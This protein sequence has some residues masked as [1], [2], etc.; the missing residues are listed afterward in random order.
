MAIEV[1][2]RF[3]Y[4]YRIDE[5]M[6]TRVIDEIEKHMVTDSYCKNHSLYTIANIYYDTGDSYLIRQSLSKPP[7]KEKLRLRSYGVPDMDSEAYLEIKKKVKGLVNKRRTALKLG[8]TYDFVKSG[9]K[10]VKREYMN[11]QVLNELE[12]FLRIHDVAPKT[13]IA[14]DRLAYFGKGSD[15]LRISFDT[16]IRSRRSELRLELGDHG[17]LLLD[18]GLY[19]MEIKTSLAMPVWLADML[20][21]LGIHRTSFS[22]YGT[23]YKEYLKQGSR[24]E[25]RFYPALARGGKDMAAAL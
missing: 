21:E 20:T 12:Y 14:Y 23:E 5:K 25:R 11:G 1:F 19:I 16:N 13:Y 6:L 4:K 3:E 8:E 24:G 9:A 10:P 7:Y 18:K 17:S 15:D 2:N 22:K